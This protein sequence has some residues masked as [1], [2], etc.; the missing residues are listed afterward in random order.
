LIE[1]RVW[2]FNGMIVWGVVA[3]VTVLAMIAEWRL[4]GPSR[5]PGACTS[6]RAK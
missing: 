1:G 5:D 6:S 3:I 2:R 4:A